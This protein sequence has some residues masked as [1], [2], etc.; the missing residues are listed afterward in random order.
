MLT[1]IRFQIDDSILLSSN[2]HFEYRI[3]SL[4][5]KKLLLKFIINIKGIYYE[6]FSN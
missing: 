4:I 5:I 3:T 2:T 1:E 6:L